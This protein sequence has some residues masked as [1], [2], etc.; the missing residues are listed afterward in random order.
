M[1]PH[2]MLGDRGAP[3]CILYEYSFSLNLE[4]VIIFLREI[5]VNQV[6]LVL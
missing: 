4:T 1:G 2:G 3:V 6:L 5:E